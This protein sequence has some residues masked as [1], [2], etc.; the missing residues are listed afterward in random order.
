MNKKYIVTNIEPIMKNEDVIITLTDLEKVNK[1][2]MKI[3]SK[4]NNENNIDIK[5]T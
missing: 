2:N 1:K 5:R 3:Y 4:G